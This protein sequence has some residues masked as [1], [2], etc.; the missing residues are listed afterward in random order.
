MEIVPKLF[1][2]IN[3]PEYLF[4]KTIISQN[5][6]VNIYTTFINDLQIEM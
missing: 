1:I 3:Y 4:N 6:F 2:D 5:N